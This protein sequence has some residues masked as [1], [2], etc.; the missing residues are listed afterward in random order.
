[1]RARPTHAVYAFP[2]AHSSSVY[3]IAADGS[4]E[5][6]WT[7]REDLVYALGLGPDGKLLLGIGNQGTVIK[8]DGDHVF[9]RLA[10]TESEQVTGF[11]R[12]ANG[13]MYVATANPGK[14][15][16]L[17]PGLESEGTFESQAF[18]AHIFSRWGR[19]TW[20]GDNVAPPP[21]WR[22]FTA[23]QCR[24][25]PAAVELYVRAGNTSDPDNSWS[26]WFG[27]YRNGAKTESPAARF[28]QWKAVL[29]G[30]SGPAPE[31]SWVN[32]AYLPKN[33]APRITG[34]ALQNPGVRVTGFRRPAGRSGTSTA[35]AIAQ[36][37]APGP[38]KF[39]ASGGE[40]PRF[41][42]P[43]QGFAQKG[44]QSVLWNAEDDNDDELIY[45]I[46]YRGESENDWKLLKDKIDQ[47]FYSWDTTSMPDGAYYLK[48]V[49]SDERSNRPGSG[50]DRR[51]RK[52]ALHGGQY[53]AHRRR[54]H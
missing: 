15:F 28:V 31:L 2:G 42:A 27:P 43:P 30:G 33:T 40:A 44:Y 20:W 22:K 24:P 3:R 25:E 17:G 16:T 32:V 37:P 48:I 12:A 13:K 52:R 36:P 18:D 26:P 49:A 9:S 8:L 53:A 34:I 51:A 11:A 21:Q 35:R 41:E 14:I 54:H 39:A 19:L 1:M 4:P 5:E 50:A 6:I 10:K 23:G 45:S 47:R 29:H 46:Y 7:S 38:V